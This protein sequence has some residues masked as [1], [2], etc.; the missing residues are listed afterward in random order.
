[1]PF[2]IKDSQVLYVKKGIHGFRYP[3]RVLEPILLGYQGTTILTACY[4][5]LYHFP[6][7]LLPP[8]PLPFSHLH[9]HSSHSSHNVLLKMEMGSCHRPLELP[10]GP[11]HAFSNVYTPLH[12]LERSALSACWS[13]QFHPSSP[14]P[15]PLL[16]LLQ[17]TKLPHS[18]C[19]ALYLELFSPTSAWLASSHLSRTTLSRSSS[20]L[21]HHIQFVSFTALY[22]SRNCSENPFIWCSGDCGST[23]WKIWLKQRIIKMIHHRY[24]LLA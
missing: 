22:S 18:P 3:R 11:H 12:D 10:D 1:M 4:R 20:V 2:Y 15:H 5:F 8:C 19:C 17:H 13:G 21:C 14:S 23:I 9:P 16:Q 24:F 7:S 6:L